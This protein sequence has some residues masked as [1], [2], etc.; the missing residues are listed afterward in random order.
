MRILSLRLKNINSLKGEWKIDFTQTPFSDNGLFAITGPTG[1]GKTTILDA[2]C[3]AL[4]HRTPRLNTISKTSNEL[5]TRGTAEALA[6]VE[7]DVKGLAY[8]AFWS[9]RRSRDKA[10]GNL[11]D[12]KVELASMADGKILASQVK[13]KS[14]MIE[15]ITGLDFARFTKSMM[16][17][18]GQFA[19]FL[20][21]DA[22]D[23]AELL[24]ELTGTEIYGLIS[25]KVHEHFTLRKNELAQLKARAEGVELLNAEQLEE[26]KS[27]LDMLSQHE[28]ELD[29]K[30]QQI[31]TH[32]EWWDKTTAAEKALIAANEGLTH[33]E[34]QYLLEK[35]GLERLAQ[36]EPAE[37]L[38]APY[39]L[40]QNSSEKHQQVIA[41]VQH[42]TAEINNAQQ[43]AA[44]THNTLA[45]AANALES[46]RKDQQ[47]QEKLLNEQVIPLDNQLQQA[48]AELKRLETDRA[49][50]EQ[51][52]DAQGSNLANIEQRLKQVTTELQR[53]ERYKVEHAQDE[54]LATQL[55]RW[56]TLLEQLEQQQRQLTARQ[57]QQADLS[58]HQHRLQSETQTLNQQLSACQH[59]VAQ[60][61]AA[62]EQINAERQQVLAGADEAQLHAEHQ[63][64]HNQQG[65][66]LELKNTS[67]R[68]QG[69]IAEQTTQQKEQTALGA[70]TNALRTE[71]QQLRDRYKQ[72]HQHLKDVEKLIE[73]EKRITDLAAERAKLQPNEA[74]PL[75]GSTEHP[76]IDQYQA[77]N[78]SETEQRR[79]TL[80]TEVEAIEQQ[81]KELSNALNKE[82]AKLEQHNQRL[83]AITDELSHLQTHWQQLTGQIAVTL[84]LSQS[85][86][87]QSYLHHCDSR[88]QQLATQL[89]Q[90]R[91]INQRFQ[92]S[93][94]ELNV[95][96]QELH[97]A[98]HALAL[99]TQQQNTVS[100]QLNQ[101]ES[102]LISQN[103]QIDQLQ[104]TLESQLTAVGRT[105]PDLSE[106][107]IWNSQLQQA[108]ARW[109][110]EINRLHDCQKTQ[111]SLETEANACKQQ[112]QQLM[113][114]LV[115]LTDSYNSAIAHRDALQQQRTALF[116]DKNADQA[117]SDAQQR[118]QD[119]EARHQQALAADQQTQHNQQSLKGQLATTEQQQAA[120][121]HELDNHAQ[122]WQSALDASPFDSQ[123][124]FEGALLPEDERN[125]LQQLKQQLDT[126]LSK[127]QAVR[128]QATQ[129][130]T[131]LQDGEQAQQ[132][133]HTPAEQVIE[134]LALVE[135]QL[136]DTTVQQ[137]TV[138]Q[139]L[140]DDAKRR[141]NQ[142]ELFAEIERSQGH[143]DDIAYLHALIGSQKGDKFR[144]F[145]QGLTL[146]HLVH[147]ANRRLDRL[148]GRY[149]LKRKSTEAL[150]L[151][152]IDTWQGDTVRDTKTLSGGESFLVSLAL[153]LALSDLVSQK[154]SIDS[155]FL[156]EGFGTLDA[157]TLD[158]ALDALDSLNASGKMIGVISH[159]EAMKER[160]PTQ[161]QVKK[162]N[163][164]GVSQLESRFRVGG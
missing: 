54:N 85:E 123:Q 87:L 55:P 134:Q 107:T 40:L 50:T 41:Q 100:Q 142:T 115:S 137:G 124:A 65:V 53:R 73:Q 160:I 11:Q 16:L 59:S 83:Q 63:H 82:E 132:W 86:A 58:R 3:L 105:M 20:N 13:A 71:V 140:E 161:I 61:K 98:N 33:A 157:E 45:H 84:G 154:T 97:K 39:T 89:E 31:R 76:L 44:V 141:Q 155:L 24:E 46:A 64:L 112:H 104:Q 30:R 56:Q 125:R 60:H 118:V 6:E 22:N 34:Q 51:Q 106:I 29:T 143:Y 136:R 8:R 162:M 74:C 108:A 121:K 35:D 17:S 127:A 43:H 47:A 131:S 146:D 151:Q 110:E 129:H 25:E 91:S 80:K 117:R 27:R 10:D 75:C 99:N 94:N 145:A 78:L 36:A 113:E 122:A 28:K 138:T 150:E 72:S 77:L 103:E 90:L 52:A 49:R 149:L 18:Q 152:V 158:T 2:I 153:A 130:L 37:K 81:G 93:S 126:N 62:L 66:R 32:K 119:C 70:S 102:E 159:I 88:L 7:F 164:L 133:Q 67:N 9:Q 120:L 14:Q 147:L 57:T 42:L 156:D 135:A 23:R 12:A 109:Q 38:R 1:A 163:G 96:E 139:S 19:A 68:H 21:A 128:E 26:L 148:H 111:S 5:M 79:E 69:L 15:Q 92:A 101:L 114:Q 95:A 4:Y 116:G 48:D 144:R